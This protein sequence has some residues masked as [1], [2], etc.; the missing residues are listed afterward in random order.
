VCF[1]PPAGRRSCRRRAIGLSAVDAGVIRTLSGSP[2][3]RSALRGYEEALRAKILPALR[4]G[5]IAQE[6][7]QR[8]IRVSYFPQHDARMI[9]ASQRLYDA[10]IERRIVHP[11]DPKLNAHV[12]DAIARHGR[13]GWRLD[14]RTAPTR[15]TP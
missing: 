11:N 8:G 15:S 6:L 7:E 5:Q 13:R 3:K 12:A 1:A 9:P 14:R 2:Y 10:I 4:A